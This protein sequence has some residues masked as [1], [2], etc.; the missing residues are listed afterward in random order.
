MWEV[1]RRVIDRA[2]GDA[3]FRAQLAAAPERALAEYDLTAAERAALQTVAA[4][5]GPGAHGLERR[6]TAHVP[7]PCGPIGP[8]APPCAPWG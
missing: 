5:A 3:A 7:C 8:D 2:C 6:Q 1:L 4:A